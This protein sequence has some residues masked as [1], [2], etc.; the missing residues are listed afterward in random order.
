MNQD[1]IQAATNLAVGERIR[2]AVKAVLEPVIEEELTSHLSALVF[3]VFPSSNPYLAVC[4]VGAIKK[5]LWRKE[6]KQ[7]MSNLLQFASGSERL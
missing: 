2:A 4:L 6:A 3:L 7:K 1:E 5:H